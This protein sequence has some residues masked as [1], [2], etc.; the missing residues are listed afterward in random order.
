MSLHNSQPANLVFDYIVLRV[1]F[2]LKIMNTR[3][4][5]LYIINQI[6]AIDYKYF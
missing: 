6:M 3:L 5:P 2:D 1:I 4:C